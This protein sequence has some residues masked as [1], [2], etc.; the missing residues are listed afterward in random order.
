ML[1]IPS[2]KHVSVTHG[3]TPIILKKRRFTMKKNNMS[4]ESIVIQIIMSHM[5]YGAEQSICFCMLWSGGGSEIQHIKYSR[6]QS[7]QLGH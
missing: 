3:A 2:Q 7:A 6:R 1:R 5:L 4:V